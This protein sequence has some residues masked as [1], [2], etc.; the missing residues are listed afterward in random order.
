MKILRGGKKPGAE[1][2]MTVRGSSVKSTRAPHV[3]AARDALQFDGA[4]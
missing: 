1:I 4:M 3:M 2:V